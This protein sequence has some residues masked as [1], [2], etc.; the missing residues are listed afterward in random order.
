MNTTLNE[1][2]QKY[3]LAAFSK[4]DTCEYSSQNK[5]KLFQFSDVHCKTT[6]EIY[7]LHHQTCDE[8]TF[9]YSGDGEVNHNGKNY[10]QTG[11]DIHICFKGDDHQPISSKTSPMKFYC[12][13]YTLPQENPLYALSRRVK[14]KIASGGE[15]IIKD[16]LG[17]ENAFHTILNL[18]YSDSFNK[19]EEHIISSTLNYFISFVMMSY[20]DVIPTATKKMSMNDSLVLYIIS[21]LRNN[22]QDSRALK[23]LSEDTG[24]SY[25]YISHTFTRKMGQNLQAFFLSLR[26]SYATELLKDK[27]VTEVAE[28]LGYATIHSF[29]KAYKNYY[30]SSPKKS[31]S[32]E[33]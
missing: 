18:L 29:S 22:I 25:S 6:N 28:L 15:P 27:N 26:M 24:Y 17:L 31:K 11:G 23:R 9:V 1:R 3:F 12:I 5:I 13:G 4:Y 32:D 2:Q 14:D 10:K 16:T 20:L 7:P 8:I 21:F 19:T 33:P 30:N